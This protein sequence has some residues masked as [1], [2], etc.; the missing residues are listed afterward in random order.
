MILLTTLG[1]YPLLKPRFTPSVG[2]A[3]KKEQRRQKVLTPEQEQE[4]FWE[5]TRIN[6][7]V[8]FI[9]DAIVIAVCIGLIFLIM[10]EIGSGIPIILQLFVSVISMTF[11]VV[12]RR[13][14]NR[15]IDRGD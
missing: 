7:C 8:T 14:F 6:S 9:C 10:R 12:L 2:Q 15:E 11:A 5:L 4:L 3:A 13:G 1:R